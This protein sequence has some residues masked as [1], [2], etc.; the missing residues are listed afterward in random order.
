MIRGALI[1]FSFPLPRHLQ[2]HAPR[3]TAAQFSLRTDLL[4]VPWPLNTW[5]AADLGAAGALGFPRSA[6]GLG[7]PTI[8]CRGAGSFRRRPV[9]IN[10]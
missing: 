4:L 7:L 1:L 9:G 10:R 6:S 8:G 5:L 3:L 2:R